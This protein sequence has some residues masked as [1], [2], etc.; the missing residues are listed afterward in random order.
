MNVLVAVELRGYRPPGDWIFE[1]EFYRYGAPGY[2]EFYTSQHL[3]T[4]STVWDSEIIAPRVI[5]SSMLH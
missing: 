5:K 1:T 3:I 2:D 4:L